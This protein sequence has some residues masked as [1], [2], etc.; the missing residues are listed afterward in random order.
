MN[1]M[2]RNI[3]LLNII[4]ALKWFV[5]MLPVTVLYF[6]QHNLSGREIFT[7]TSCYS[8]SIVLF[9]VPSG[10]IAD[11]KG[12]K[13]SIIA[14]LALSVIGN[15]FFLLPGFY[16]FAVAEILLGIGASFI[17]GC[18][19]ALFYDSLKNLKKE[20][21]FKKL[22]GRYRAYGNFSEA[23]AGLIGGFLA[24]YALVF[25]VYG[26]LT[27]LLAGLII[28]F[29]ITEPEREIIQTHKGRIITL[30]KV[31]KYSFAD[32]KT[33]KWLIFF[34][35]VL[36]AATLNIAWFSQFFF[37]EINLSPIYFGVV[38]A[39][40]QVASGLYAGFGHRYTDL[41]GKHKAMAS[42]MLFIFAGYIGLA[43]SGN[44]F[45]GIAF[46]LICFAVRGINLP[47]LGFYLHK[48]VDSDK[49]ATVISVKSLSVRLF[50]SSLAPFFGYIIDNRGLRLSLIVAGSVY[51]VFGTIAFLA[52]V[53]VMKWKRI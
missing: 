23:G 47:V 10:Y 43:F 18:D 8:L 21:K 40:I 9:E 24:S 49:R 16:F 35:S 30:L 7:L 50:Y 25:T 51:A 53:K 17:S 22:I 42:L 52:L 48:E 15:L 32:N 34:S 4:Y 20:N 41:L 39:I 26:R 36:G 12:R 45:I 11:L 2:I 38:W 19:S 31:V 14:G 27:V 37:K 29:F 13:K 33:V 44:I 1:K 3:R 46:I 5:L 6:K 28:S